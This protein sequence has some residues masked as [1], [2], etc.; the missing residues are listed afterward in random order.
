MTLGGFCDECELLTSILKPYHG[1]LLCYEC[2]R[3][4]REHDD[5][6][7]NFKPRL[8]EEEGGDDTIQDDNSE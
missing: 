8:G 5:W 7:A 2:F 4:A 6:E 1:R 3:V